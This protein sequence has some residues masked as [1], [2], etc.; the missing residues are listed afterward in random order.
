M[1]AASKKEAAGALLFWSICS[2]LAELGSNSEGGCTVAG[3][4]TGALEGGVGSRGNSLIV[5]RTV[6]V[7]GLEELSGSLLETTGTNTESGWTPAC[8]LRGAPSV[9]SSA[10]KFR[11]SSAVRAPA[12]V[13]A[14]GSA[15]V[16]IESLEER[17]KKAEGETKKRN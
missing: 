8:V 9:N 7:R 17:K 5:Y 15:L 11:G 13:N 16:G 4:G 3:E 2:V 12:G 6:G 10:L 14:R 1:E